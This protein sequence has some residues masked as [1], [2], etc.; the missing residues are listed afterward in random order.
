MRL[1]HLERLLKEKGVDVNIDLL[2]QRGTMQ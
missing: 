2:Q 1:G